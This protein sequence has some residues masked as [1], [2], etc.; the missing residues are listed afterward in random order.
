MG[1]VI[2]TPPV[3]REKEQVPVSTLVINPGNNFDPAAQGFSKN[4]GTKGNGSG[5]IQDLNTDHPFSVRWAGSGKDRAGIRRVG[6]ASKRL[7]CGYGVVLL[8]FV[9][10]SDHRYPHPPGGRSSLV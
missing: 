6:S 9:L 4:S 1:R 3:S 10:Q 2:I 7:A 5:K 8:S